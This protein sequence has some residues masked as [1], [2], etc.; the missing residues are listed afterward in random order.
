[1]INVDSL[2]ARVIG[3]FGVITAVIAIYRIIRVI[4]KL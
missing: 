2:G 1:M 3:S 4:P